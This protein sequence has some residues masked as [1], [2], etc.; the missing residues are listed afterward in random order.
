MLSRVLGWNWPG[1]HWRGGRGGGVREAEGEEEGAMYVHVLVYRIEC[2][3]ATCNCEE[4]DST[5]MI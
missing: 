4:N 3:R 2:W 5:P 1:A